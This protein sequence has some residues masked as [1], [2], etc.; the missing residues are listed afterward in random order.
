[1]NVLVVLL[2]AAAIFVLAGRFYSRFV[3]RSLGEDP[4]R[5]TP[6]V[7]CNDGRRSRT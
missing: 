4:G 1:M 7:T 2:A 3:A 6:A 5:A